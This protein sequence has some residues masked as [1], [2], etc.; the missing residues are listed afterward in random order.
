MNGNKVPYYLDQKQKKYCL[1]VWDISLGI[2]AAFVVASVAAVAIATIVLT[3]QG[4]SFQRYCIDN[5][6]YFGQ[7][8]LNSNDRTIEWD[9]QY[10]LPP[11]NPVLT[12]QIKGPIAPGTTDGG[13]F[14]ALCGVPS[15]LACDTLIAGILQGKLTETYQGNS[16][17]TSIN[18]IREFPRRYYLELGIASNGTDLLRAPL[19]TKCG[20]T[21]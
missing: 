13:L 12:L 4:E 3:S 17:K 11:E 21:S 6:V 19:G 14:L 20:T 10:V 8:G 15:T 2:V 5:D 7:L 9:L 16:L 18:A 1:W